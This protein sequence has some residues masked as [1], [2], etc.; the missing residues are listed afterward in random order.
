MKAKYGKTAALA[1]FAIALSVGTTAFAAGTDES[2]YG[3]LDGQQ[4]NSGRHAQYAEIAGLET[5]E[6]REAYFEARGIGEGSAYSTAEHLAAEELA[7]AGVI[8]QETADKI[9]S[10]ASAKHQTIHA[11][12]AGKGDMTPEE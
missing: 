3:Y 11:S 5:D 12:Y 9:V 8:D 2:S 6:A 1:A 7:E 4:K 10:G